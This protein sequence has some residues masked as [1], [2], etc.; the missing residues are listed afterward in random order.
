M[1]IQYFS[2]PMSGDGGFEFRV[3]YDVFP[4]EGGNL[5]AA[6]IQWR[7]AGSYGFTSSNSAAS[8]S[9]TISGTGGF[10]QSST[11]NFYAP[12]GGSID[13]Q[14]I[15]THQAV[16]TGTSASISASFA[17][18]TQGAGTG[19]F[20]TLSVPL[21]TASRATFSEVGGPAITA[22]DAG[23]AITIHTNRQDSSYTHD[24]TYEFGSA[25]GTVGEG[26]G[27]STPWT[28]P[29]SMLT[30]IPN[31]T[32]AAGTIRT[33]TKQ[34]STVVGSTTTGFVLR[35]GAG[36]IPTVTGVGAVELNSTVASVVGVPVQSLS[37]LQLNVMA[38][39][40]YG[41][42]ITARELTF[43][44][45]TMPT[46]STVNVPVAGSVP[47]KGR[48][49]DSRGRQSA[50]WSGA[51]DVLPYT[52]PQGSVLAQRA[53]VSNVADPDGEYIRVDVS[54]AVQSLI[55]G[56]QRNGLTLRV[57][58]R[59][60]SGGVWT[61]RNVIVH[62][63]LTY[64]SALQVAGG[65][66]FSSGSSWDVRV[67]VEDKFATYTEIAVVATSVSALELVGTKVAIGKR[68]EQGALDV[69]PGGIRDDGHWVI[70]ESNVATDAAR[71]IVELATQAEVDAG[72]DNTR[73]VTPATLRN[74]AWGMRRIED[75]RGSY[76]GSG[77][78]TVTFPVGAFTK[79]P[80]VA[81]T[82]MNHANVVSPR[83]AANPTAT[84][85]QVQ[86]FTMPGGGLVAVDFDWIATQKGG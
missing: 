54:A 5:V 38:A 77:A 22:F 73:A 46:G 44:G 26:I 48:A 72:T 69:G 25:T 35:A 82:P 41:S 4:Q 3:A 16:I 24:I 12:A 32:Q 64:N 62:G 68:H 2:V 59:P 10:T 70:N 74:A 86:F 84:S 45:A 8:Y 53:N 81:V 29:L 75:G 76:P 78:V 14:W 42:T 80:R 28:P 20:S 79:P 52:P 49:T 63:S 43:Q 61:P 19:S 6:T 13:W 36:V 56:T 60:H 83:M 57:A 27:A 11:V 7:R 15:A 71:G 51:L 9:L 47:V 18:G 30:A 39:G 66:A 40:A 85:F 65:A 37:Q 50:E 17:T 1:A 23:H 31:L 67:Q 21:V 33:V 55:N 34:G 58:T